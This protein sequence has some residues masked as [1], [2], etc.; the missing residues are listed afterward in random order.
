[1]ELELKDKNNKLWKVQRVL[2]SRAGCSKM[3]I[4]NPK[5]KERAQTE[6]FPFLTSIGLREGTYI[7]FGSPSQF[8]SK[9]T[10]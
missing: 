10:L 1:M 6:A 7:V 8:L 3:K 2:S 5:G 4:I 9:K